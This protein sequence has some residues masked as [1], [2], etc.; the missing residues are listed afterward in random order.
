MA[1]LDQLHI[2]GIRNFPSDKMRVVRFQYPLTLIVGE[3]GCGKTTVIECIKFALTN[4]YPQGALSG[5]N[6]VHDPKIGNKAETHAIVKLQCVCENNDTICVV[7]SLLLTQK[8]DKENCTSKDTTISR[9][10]PLTGHQR[11]LGCLQSESVEE[12]CNVIGVSKAILNNVIFCHQENSDWPLGEGKKVKEMFDEIFDT[13]KYNK[14]LDLIKLQRDRLKKELPTIK[15][16]YDAALNYKKESDSK[17]QLVY[18]NTQKREQS[19]KELLSIDEARKPLDQT[20]TQLNEKMMNIN[21]RNLQ[22]DRKKTE[23]DMV[24]K[25]S[26]ELESSI[27]ELF[28]GD[29]CDL[30]AKL[31]LFIVDLDEKRMHL[32]NQENLKSQYIQEERQISTHI[33]EAQVKLGKLERDEETHRKLSDHLKTNLNNLAD[34]LCLSTTSKSQYTQEE[35]EEVIKMSQETIVN[36]K[37]DITVLERT[38]IDKENLDQVKID[39]LREKRASLES[40]IKHSNERIEK[41]K[42]ELYNVCTQ[43]NEVTHSQSTLQVLQTKLNRVNSQIEELAVA[44][45]S[46]QLKTDIEKWKSSRNDLE[47]NL[48][49]IDAEVNYLQ[50]QNV[51]LNEIKSLKRRKESKFEDIHLLKNK[52][53]DVFLSLFGVIPQENFKTELDKVLSTTSFEISKL[54]KEFNAKDRDLVTRET[55]VANEEKKY[56]EYQRNLS[57]L[58]DRMELVLGSNKPFKDELSNVTKELE[59]EQEKVSR[60]SSTEYMFNRYID[61][62]E[63]NE[64]RCPLCKRFFEPDY[65][66]PDL[67]S[68]LKSKLKNIPGDTST[69]KKKIEHLSKQ[70]SNLQGL[71]PVYEDICK[72]QGEKI[73]AIKDELSELR[74]NV[75]T[76]KCELKKLK[77]QLEIPQKKEKICLTLQGDVSLLDQN[78]KDLK[79]IQCAIEDHESKLS[80]SNSRDVN[81]EQVLDQQKETKNEINTLRSKIEDG[82]SKLSTHNEKLRSLQQQKNEIHSKQLT[83]QGGAGMLKSL[84]DRKHELQAENLK[85]QTEIEEVSKKIAPIEIQLNLAKNELESLKKDHGS[86]LKEE[87]E[88]IQK[89]S[90]QLGEVK[91]IKQEMLNYERLGTLTQLSEIRETLHKLNEKKEQIIAK[92]ETCESDINKINQFISNQS[93]EKMDLDNNMKLIEKKLELAQLNLDVKSLHRDINDLD[94]QTLDDE[95]QQIHI[96]KEQL[97]KNKATILGR[98]QEIDEIIKN[99]Q[100]DLKKDYLKN[101]DQKFL[102][103]AYRLKLNNIIMSDLS[104]Y[105]GALENCV[106]KYHQKKMESINKLIRDYWTRVYQG[107]DIHF[108]MIETEMSGNLDK[109]RTYNT[110]RVVQRKNGVFQD[111]RNRC[112]AGQRVLASL[113]I[114]LA[115]AETFS[116]NCGIFALDEPTTNLDCKNAISLSKALTLLVEEKRNQ[117]NFQLIVITHDEDFIENLT[118]IDKAYVVRIVRDRNGLS[119]IQYPENM[120]SREFEKYDCAN[121]EPNMK[122]LKNKY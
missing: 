25:I 42:K 110:Y 78:I 84:E 3:N 92:R 90:Q 68:D 60:L 19:T 105:H 89:Y 95:I 50:A 104:K 91:R 109:R 80:G 21:R 101:A 63:E 2:Q 74:D 7:R 66:V 77:E 76:V 96:K 70:Q 8:N 26:K 24:L 56:R 65:S 43:I 62:L 64:P 29:K 1:L 59:D 113:I 108:I 83:L 14:A 12:M 51:I 18:N 94:I 121:F 69:G 4:E 117:K 15:T 79:N 98:I 37:L 86:K 28:M 5:K 40:Q 45:N 116:R 58:L 72:L 120:V 114:R 32:K 13:T 97:G 35:S 6:F 41:N 73:P 46:E 99:T 49:C 20:L 119:D 33:N 82:Q 47:D 48:T 102:R 67:V 52:H 54:Q 11:N 38:Y 115:L 87:R 88:K 122:K 53:N 107:N 30:Q 34:A 22:Y 10:N 81:L 23:R 118:A 85:Y 27:I 16:G 112:S 17:K 36:H 93:A 103:Y 111:M 106:V 55:H 57:E 61:K 31:D 9:K 100:N 75:A 44:L 39:S 71:K